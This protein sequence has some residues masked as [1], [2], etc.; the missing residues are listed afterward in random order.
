MEIVLILNAA[1]FELSNHI[2]KKAIT[3]I[4]RILVETSLSSLPGFVDQLKIE[5]FVKVKNSLKSPQNH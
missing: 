3:D 5:P 1:L 4:K 2:K